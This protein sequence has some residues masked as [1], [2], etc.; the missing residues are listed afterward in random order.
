MS[1]SLYHG[2]FL[3]SPTP[4]VLEGNKCSHGCFYCFAN[5][6]KS[7][8]LFSENAINCLEKPEKIKG[9][10]GYFLQNRYPIMISNKTDPLCKSNEGLT[11]TLMDIADEKNHNFFWQTKGGCSDLENR[12][13]NGKKCAVYLSLTSNKT[14]LLKQIEPKAPSYSERLKFMKSLI[15]AGHHV[16]VGLNPLIEAWWD[17][18]YDE[19]DRWAEMGVRFVWVGTL[20]FNRFQVAAFS[21]LQKKRFREYISYGR[22]KEKEDKEFV[23]GIMDYIDDIGMAA[24][25][26]E[27]QK[28][29]FWSPLDKIYPVRLKTFDDFLSHLK[30]QGGD[31]VFD[32]E[33]FY[34]WSGL[35]VVEPQQ[36]HG[37]RDYIFQFSM[38][39]NNKG[40]Q[41]KP[42][43]FREVMEF[44]WRWTDYPTCFRNRRIYVAC[45]NEETAF[46]DPQGR[47]MLLY[48]NHITDSCERIV[49]EK[50]NELLKGAG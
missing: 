19:I 24:F 12:I 37:Y 2:E 46:T 36:W 41:Y 28:G 22:K 23:Y 38:H 18:L 5:L 30:H 50:P 8:R 4:L 11:Q 3:I 20:H 32:F 14:N 9:P 15:S 7:T 16:V 1:L 13:I 43:S 34:H 42:K 45:E 33:Y 17:N 6:N 26:G 35:D 29:N 49:T 48:S 31:V 47:Y 39:M 44:I 21:D 25:D 40:D 27:S 10:K